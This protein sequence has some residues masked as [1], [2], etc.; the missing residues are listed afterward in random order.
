MYPPNPLACIGKSNPS[1]A[2]QSRVC[3][4]NRLAS[5]LPGVRQGDLDVRMPVEETEEFDPGITGGA[6]D[7]GLKLGSHF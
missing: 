1:N 5:Q 4:G 3:R 7:A 2:P 6:N